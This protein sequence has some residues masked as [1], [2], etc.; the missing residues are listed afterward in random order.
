M[1]LYP[2][3]WQITNIE[4]ADAREQIKSSVHRNQNTNK[5]K[6]KSG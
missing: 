5:K 1:L 4:I 6:K 3:H 2:F